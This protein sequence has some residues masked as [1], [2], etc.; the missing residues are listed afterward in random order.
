MSER[1][2]IERWMTPD[3]VSTVEWAEA[4]RDYALSKDN[5]ITLS[6]T[7]LDALNK[8]HE[9]AGSA[10]ARVAELEAVGTFNEGVEAAAKEV[11]PACRRGDFATMLEGQG[12]RHYITEGDGTRRYRGMCAAVNIRAL[13]RPAPAAPAKIEDDDETR[14]AWCG[15]PLQDSIEKG[16]VRG[17]CS[18]RPL[19]LIPWKRERAK[20]EAEQPA[21]PAVQGK[22]THDAK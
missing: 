17:N 12:L 6:E 14:C 8:C 16:C 11:C 3:D 9:R 15:W 20:R 4:W 22:E 1:P 10:Q 2:P 18:M 19:P 13:Q 7:F 5:A 21:S